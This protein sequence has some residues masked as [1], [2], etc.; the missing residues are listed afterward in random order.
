MSLANHTS[1]RLPKYLLRIVR[2]FP[3]INSKKPQIDHLCIDTPPLPKPLF[4]LLTTVQGSDQ[5]FVS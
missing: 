2:K 3:Q 4:R 5:V 1:R